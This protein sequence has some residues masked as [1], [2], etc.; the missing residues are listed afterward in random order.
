MWLNNNFSYV[1]CNNLN[2]VNC[3]EYWEDVL[4]NRDWSM[5]KKLSIG[6]HRYKQIKV[7]QQTN[8]YK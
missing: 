5:L 6:S 3:L 7:T 1:E 2:L 4:N 8:N